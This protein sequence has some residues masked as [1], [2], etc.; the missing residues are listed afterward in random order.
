MRLLAVLIMYFVWDAGRPC[1]PVGF[2]EHKPVLFCNIKPGIIRL[3]QILLL[4]VYRV[5]TVWYS[6]LLFR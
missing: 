3:M 1:L 2:S 6:Y 4:I 5:L